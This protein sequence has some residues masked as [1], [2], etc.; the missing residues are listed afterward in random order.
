[1]A[2]DLHAARH[3]HRQAL[4]G[5]SGAPEEVAAPVR[6]QRGNRD[7][8]LQIVGREAPKHRDPLH[9]AFQTLTPRVDGHAHLLPRPL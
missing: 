4:G 2:D 9:G 7:E 8:A 5:I 3:E 1:V 6:L